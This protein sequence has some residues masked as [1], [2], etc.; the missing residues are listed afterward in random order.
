MLPYLRKAP[1]SRFLFYTI[2]ILVEV[3][4]FHTQI[5]VT[6]I[7]PFVGFW[8]LYIIAS[9]PG[10]EKYFRYLFDW[11]GRYCYSFYLVHLLYVSKSE[12]WFNWLLGH[13]IENREVA[14][15]AQFLIATIST[16]LFSIILYYSIEKPGINLGRRISQHLWPAI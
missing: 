3:V 10:F 4:A 6:L 14:I 8:F 7:E 11:L 15:I 12:I 2:F 9:P 16:V 5:R 13:W 1:I